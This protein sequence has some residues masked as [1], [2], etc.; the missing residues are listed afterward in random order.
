MKIAAVVSNTHPDITHKMLEIAKSRAL[1]LGCSI[2]SIVFVDGCF[3]MPLAVKKCLETE[4]AGVITLG[5]VIKGETDHDKLILYSIVPKFIDLALEFSKPV[6][7]GIGGPNISRD[8]CIARIESHAR[9]AV[10][11]VVNLARELK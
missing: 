6:G 9:K 11:A 3:E 2:S 4:V 8:Q 1:I 5:A 7:L 10:D